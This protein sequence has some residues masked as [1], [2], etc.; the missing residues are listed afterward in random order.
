M[1]LLSGGRGQITRPHPGLVADQPQGDD[2]PGPVAGGPVE[3]VQTRA[4]SL[5]SSASGRSRCSARLPRVGPGM[6]EVDPPDRR[7]A[8]A[9]EPAPQLGQAPEP[10]DAGVVLGD[11][12]RVDLGHGVDGQ[13]PGRGDV[14]PSPSWPLAAAS[15]GRSP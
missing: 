4:R 2:R 1:A 14:P 15:A 6:V 7:V 3:P 13:H 12:R 5:A 10:G 9:V 11:G 8:V